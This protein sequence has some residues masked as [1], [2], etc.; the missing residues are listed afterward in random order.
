[1]SNAKNSDIPSIFY[2]HDISEGEI[3]W[4]GDTKKLLGHKP[5]EL[6][7][8][9]KFLKLLHEKDKKSY[10]VN[11]SSF[12]DEI[13]CQYS[14]LV[15]GSEL[16]LKEVAIKTKLGDK[17]FLH[18]IITKDDSSSTRAGEGK[19]NIAIRS[20]L[21]GKFES[22]F[23]ENL[24]KH[25][26]DGNK[27]KQT[28]SLILVSIDNLPMIMNWQGENVA[29]SVMEDLGKKINELLTD[30]SVAYRANTDQYGIIVKNPTNNEM[31][32]LVNSIARMVSLYKHPNLEDS[33]HLRL[34]VGS[35]SFPLGVRDEIDVIN[36]AYLA[37]TN[38]KSMEGEFYCDFEDAKRDH[39][40]AQNEMAQLHYLQEAFR[41]K[42]LVIAYQPVVS[43]LD[44]N[45]ISYECL[46]RINDGRGRFESAGRLIGVAEKMGTVETIDE[47]VLKMA[48]EEIRHNHNIKININVSNSTT[49]SEQWLK[50]CTQ[51]LHDEKVASRITFE[52]TETAAQKDL[53]KTAYFTAAIQGMG[54]N[55]SLDDFGVGF[56]SF[57][58]LRS[59]SINSIKIDGSF[60]LGLEENKENLIF[61]KSLVDFGKSYGL[62]TIAECVET[63]DIAKQLMELGVD[64]MQGYY[65]G[66]PDVH[67][68]WLKKTGT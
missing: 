14:V 32:L 67:K 20:I 43:S 47:Y 49:S 54:S 30:G 34:S 55:V 4:Y 11:I 59:L 46:L 63:G 29:L 37:L 56:T 61:I 21:T 41:E 8:R 62:E 24:R 39:I 38:A 40:D 33:V 3:K 7:T 19:Y 25:Y 36:K 13:N 52:I 17:Y 57:R 31:E 28:Y 60:I 9:Q 15:N 50:M 45:I 44:G 18:G 23:L 66:A 26:L 51:E 64:F 10:E 58:Q 2:V 65:F 1:V 6:N 27:N 12:V 5:E 35:V 48:I 22:T 53:R 16:S 68:P 42:R